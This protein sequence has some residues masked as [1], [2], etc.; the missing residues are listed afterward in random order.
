MPSAGITK[1]RAQGA[2]EFLKTHAVVPCDHMAVESVTTDLGGDHLR[3]KADRRI[4]LFDV[5]KERSKFAPE[6]G[7]YKI[8]TKSIAS[9]PSDSRG[10]YDACYYLPWKASGGIVEI[11]LTPAP[12]VQR[13][14]SGA[15]T[16]PPKP[17]RF[18]LG[19]HR[20]TPTRAPATPNPAA[21]LDPDVFFTTQL[22]GCS[23][24]IKGSPTEPTVYH[25]GA[26]KTVAADP[27]KYWHD[28]FLAVASQGGT[29]PGAFVEVN[30]SHYNDMQRANVGTVH[31]SARKNRN[32]TEYAQVLIND[33]RRTGRPFYMLIVSGWGNVFGLR[34]PGTRAW[35]FYRQEV[36]H[37]AY[38]RTPGAKF[39][40][41]SVKS[42]SRVAALTQVFP[43]TRTLVTPRTHCK[44]L[45]P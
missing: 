26:G 44:P 20:E 32:F 15:V 33:E 35:A 38:A 8:I 31:E 17:G 22:S 10:D 25:A 3:L 30:K 19:T 41:P 28:L 4:A 16:A 9:V 14:R 5:V 36:V 45:K 6:E 39:T 18:Q 12:A 42:I 40:D 37:I 43:G 21:G 23:V 7:A 24:F 13:G 1:F 27:T 11:T 29:G 34:D 2:L